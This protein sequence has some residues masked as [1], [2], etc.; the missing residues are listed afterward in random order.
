[1][2]SQKQIIEFAKKEGFAVTGRKLRYWSANGLIPVSEMKVLG[3]GKGS[4]SLYPDET[5]KQVVTICKQLAQKRSLVEVGWSLW[6][7]GFSVSPEVAKGVLHNALKSLRDFVTKIQD[8]ESGGVS[9]YALDT[10]I[11]PDALPPFVPPEDAQDAPHRHSRKELY[12]P[13]GVLRGISK[14]L[15][16]KKYFPTLLYL[17]S[18]A[19]V[20]PTD[21][22]DDDPDF[23]VEEHKVDTQVFSAAVDEYLPSSILAPAIDPYPLLAEIRKFVSPAHLEICLHEASDETL[24]TAYQEIDNIYDLL[25]KVFFML[26]V[27]FE[28]KA[29]RKSIEFEKL[30]ADEQASWLLI[31]LSLRGNDGL[32][33]NYKQL[34]K[35]VIELL[36]GRLPAEEPFI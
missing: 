14:K 17:I 27:L 25:W 31:W 7:S 5:G 20:K 36:E 8:K 13:H 18:L 30:P 16:A 24:R 23:L 12:Q 10:F 35:G 6:R 33:Q 28:G 34:S 21:P 1:M 2:I 15:G 29:P 22:Y 32:Y 3:R 9:D 26:K 19:Y 11:S 4:E